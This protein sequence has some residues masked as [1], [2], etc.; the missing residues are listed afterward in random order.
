MIDKPLTAILPS[1]YWVADFPRFT[2]KANSIERQLVR[3]TYKFNP[4]EIARF[5]ARWTTS[6]RRHHLRRRLSTPTDNRF[7]YRRSDNAAGRTA[8]SNDCHCHFP[9]RLASLSRS[10][11]RTSLSAFAPAIPSHPLLKM[12][13]LFLISHALGVEFHARSHDFII[14]VTRSKR[15][16]GQ[17]DRDLAPGKCYAEAD[18]PPRTE[19]ETPRSPSDD[20]P[21]L[22][23]DPETSIPPAIQHFFYPACLLNNTFKHETNFVIYAKIFIF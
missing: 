3:V 8:Q 21:K 14:N 5:P 16:S 23:S 20:E 2:T 9:I 10:D 22:R 13:C 6:T 4:K 15:M 1:D 19:I 12:R 7:Q 11:V 17:L 18:L